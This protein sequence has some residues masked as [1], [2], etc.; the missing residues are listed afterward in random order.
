MIQTYCELYV[1]LYYNCKSNV[2][3]TENFKKKMHAYGYFLLEI[4]VSR[5]KTSLF[6]ESKL[7]LQ[8]NAEHSGD[9]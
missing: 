7:S 4:L 2:K 9:K 8:V 3:C 1:Y 5:Q 6:I